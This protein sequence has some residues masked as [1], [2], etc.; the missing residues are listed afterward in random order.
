MVMKMV[1]VKRG[2]P[3]VEVLYVEMAERCRV[4]Q[5]EL[6]HEVREGNYA[7]MLSRARALHGQVRAF[8]DLLGPVVDKHL[9]ERRGH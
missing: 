8:C 3:P 5:Q 4:L 7:G 9:T 1:S 6:L 2:A